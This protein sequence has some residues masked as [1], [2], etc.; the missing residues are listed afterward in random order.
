MALNLLRNT[1]AFFTLAVDATTGEVD[2]TSAD[3]TLIWEIQVL[4]GLSFSQNTTAETI[5]LNEAG[6]APTRGQRSFNSSLDPADITFS[7]YVR[8]ATGPTAE[9]RF[10][11]NALAGKIAIGTTNA[12]WSGGAVSFANSNVH[13]LQKFG[14]IFVMDGAA[15]VIDNCALESA[16]IDFGLD[17]LATIA[18]TAKGT[19]IRQLEAV[20]ISAGGTFSGGMTTS[21]NVTL[22]DTSARYIANKLSTLT[23]TKGI[24]GVDTTAYDVAITGG[25][26]T[27]ANNLT[28]LTPANLGTVNQPV[29]YFTGTRAISGNVTAYL[30]NGGTNDTGDLMSELLAGSTT[31]TA[32]A[33][34]LDLALGGSGST[35]K[36]TLSLPAAVVQIPSVATEQVVSTT[37]NF[38]AQGYA[39]AVYD[40]TA[41][42]E[43]TLTYTAS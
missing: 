21:G 33:Y 10:L 43:A 35:T 42:N 1:R 32:P 26:I 39:G 40:I 29:T 41:S 27:F 38:T 15:F 22:K 34:K 4:D 24:N 8:P 25:N 2:I 31:N 16:S 19:K 11:W 9:E 30:R 3:S 7:T 18:W 17:S 12:A 13:Q 6:A 5:T 14:M 28:Y 37:L 20:T 23:L 36:L